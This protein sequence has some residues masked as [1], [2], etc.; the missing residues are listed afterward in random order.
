MY[1][2]SAPKSNRFF[3]KEKKEKKSKKQKGQ[4]IAVEEVTEEA[5]RIS[6]EPEVEEVS[7]EK[8]GDS[9]FSKF[10]KKFQKS[11]EESSK[12]QFLKIKA[13]WVSIG[14]KMI[15]FLLAA[16]L[17]IFVVTKLRNK[18]NSFDENIEKMREVAYTYYKVSS[19][20]P[21][22]PDEEVVMTLEDMIKGSLLPELKDTKNNVCSKEYSYVSLVNRENDNYELNVY[23]S[24]G[25][26][27]KSAFY[28]ITYPSTHSSNNSSTGSV[29]NSSGGSTNNSSNSSSNNSTN[30]NGNVNK[31]V[32]KVT[33]Y[34]MK[35][36]VKNERTYS[37]PTGYLLDGRYCVKEGETVVEDATVKYRVIPEV[38]QPANEKKYGS[39]YEYVDATLVK[40]EE[41]LKCPTGYQLRNGKCEME[42]TVKYKN[43]TSYTCPNGGILSGNKCLFTTN[44][45]YMDEELY[46]KNGEVRDG[47]CYL[48]ESASVRCIY[49]DYDSSKNACYTTYS[50]Y[51]KLS[52]WLFDG[53]VVFSASKKIVETDQLRYEKLETLSN[54]K[55]RYKRYVKIN[56]KTCDN[57]DVLSGRLCKHYDSSYEERYCKNS[58]YSL[59]ADKSE[60][61]LYEAMVSRKIKATY[62]C[63]SGYLK[64]GSGSSTSCYKYEAAQVSSLKDAYCS[65]NYDLTSDGRCVR[66]LNPTITSE[67]VYTCPSGYTKQGTGSKTKCFKKVEKESYLYCSKSEATLVGNRCII[68][69]KTEF[70]GYN[71]PVGFKKNGNLC[72]KHTAN[73][74]ILATVTEVPS[75]STEIIWSKT[76]S[77][78]GWTWTGNT[79]EESN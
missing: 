18:G 65:M 35:R 38:N 7:E 59:T 56:Q 4:E 11:D 66:V 76:K 60:C 49:G 69:E 9:F 25:G 13:D 27:S 20:R 42:G 41:N 31:P 52:D 58:K 14:V 64:R 72:I 29:N 26:E 55:V 6:V 5:A 61:F 48:K 22:T 23:L 28:E 34:E 68:P 44:A 12:K 21:V 67:E 33:L 2:D 75:T 46:C 73:D 32:T 63:P 79:K 50:S 17:V 78:N 3:H 54:G 19:H 43:Q 51:T 57:G 71:C 47:R 10:K 45:T 37:C 1:E 53:I 36:N 15:F 62:T 30:S 40:S 77:L 8:K 74:T 16:F 70:L 39:E 24:C